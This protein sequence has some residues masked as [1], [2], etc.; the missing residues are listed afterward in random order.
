MR[1]TEELRNDHEA[2]RE[3]LAQLEE[4]LPL[5]NTAPLT[6]LNLIRTLIRRLHTHTEQEEWL[7][8]ALQE[9]VR[10]KAHVATGSFPDEH[11]DQQRTLRHLLELFAK[12]HDAPADQVDAYATH[13]ID[14][15][16]EHMAKEEA[17][18][19]PLAD[20]VLGVAGKEAR[21]E[22]RVAAHR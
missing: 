22:R 9:R 4:W 3:Q 19:F 2:L 6:L 1:A 12:G 18:L 10:G 21:H 8:V 13:L 11:Q 5:L 16:R 20:R 7:L 17:E 15:L 14:S